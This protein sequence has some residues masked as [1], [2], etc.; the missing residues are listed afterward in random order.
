MNEIKGFLEAE[1]AETEKKIE[2]ETN[3]QGGF[4]TYQLSQLGTTKQVIENLLRKWR[5]YEK[6]K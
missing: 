5:L 2:I 4:Y 1:L 3:K 6:P